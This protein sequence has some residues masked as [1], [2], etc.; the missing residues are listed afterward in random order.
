M[1]KKLYRIAPFFEERMWG[2]NR[3]RTEF[4]YVTEVDP[5]GEAYNVVALPNHAD[6]PVVG[7]DITLS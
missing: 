3:L 6:C 1:K 7:E 2:G 4:G 5:I